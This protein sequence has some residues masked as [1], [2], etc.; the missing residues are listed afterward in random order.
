MRFR[1]FYRKMAKLFANSGNTDQRLHSAVSDLGLL[2]V[3]ITFLGVFRLQ[4][5]KG[6]AYYFFKSSSFI[7][8]VRY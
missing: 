7:K 8:G 3:P 6:E 2:Y 1:Y 5:V 4:W